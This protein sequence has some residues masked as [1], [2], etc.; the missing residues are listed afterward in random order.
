MSSKGFT[1]IELMIT[2]LLVAIITGFALFQYGEHVRKVKLKKVWAE[3][4]KLAHH[5]QLFFRKYKTY[6]GN[7]CKLNMDIDC[8]TPGM[9]SHYNYPSRVATA[10]PD[11]S[12]ERIILVSIPTGASTYEMTWFAPTPTFNVPLHMYDAVVPENGEDTCYLLRLDSNGN[13]I[14]FDVA[15]NLVPV[16]KCS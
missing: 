1:L 14:V 13:K 12:A 4:E 15:M 16:E 10:V 5:E 6:S 8:S 11:T 3:L 7:V 9:H 2:V